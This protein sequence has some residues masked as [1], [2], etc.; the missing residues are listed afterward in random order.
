MM[1]SNSKLLVQKAAK[2]GMQALATAGNMVAMWAISE[3]IGFAVTSFNNFIHSAE[4]AKNQLKVLTLPLH[5]C[6]Q[7][8]LQIPP[9]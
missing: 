8:L 2:V 4:N 7:N 3:V 5:L 9:K 6:N 1:P